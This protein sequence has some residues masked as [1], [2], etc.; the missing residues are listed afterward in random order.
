MEG[1][2]MDQKVTKGEI[3]ELNKWCVHNQ[4]LGHMNPFKDFLHTIQHRILTE[5]DK[6]DTLEDIYWLSQQYQENNIY[7]NAVTSDMQTLQGICHGIISDGVIEDLEVIELYGWIEKNKHLSEIYPYAEL[8]KLLSDILDDGVIDDEEIKS[9]K[10]FFQEFVELNDKKLMST[11][12]EDTTGI[13][14]SKINPIEIKEP[15]HGKWVCITGELNK[16]TKETLY[17]RVER[18][19]GVRKNNVSNKLNYLIIGGAGSPAWTFASY[20]RK[21]EDVISRQKKG[22]DIKII[23]ENDFYEYLERTGS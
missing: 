10:S 15:I 9:I 2:L 16:G 23:K 8:Y 7:Y 17:S 22:H 1:I 12:K 18:N 19:G 6:L 4:G 21:V 3:N 11:I 13:S 14:F 20:G 5:S